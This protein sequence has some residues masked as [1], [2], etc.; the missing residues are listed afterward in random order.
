MRRDG[1]CLAEKGFVIS[2]YGLLLM[3]T[4]H[5]LWIWPQG[6]ASRDVTIIKTTDGSEPSGSRL[7]ARAQTV[8]PGGYP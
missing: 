5:P 7:S 4:A 2:I 3:E 8:N 6:R 1:A